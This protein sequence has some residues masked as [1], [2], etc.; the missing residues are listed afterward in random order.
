MNNQTLK[1]VFHYVNNTLFDGD[2][3]MPA[4]VLASDEDLINIAGFEVD[5]IFT[6]EPFMIA[7]NEDANI[8]DTMVHEMIHLWQYQNN[9]Y[10]GH[11]GWFRVWCEK[12]IDLYYW[13]ML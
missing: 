5:G 3:E 10:M 4:L 13:R 11:E 8:F 1:K 6:N 9:K 12:A 7:I 2:L